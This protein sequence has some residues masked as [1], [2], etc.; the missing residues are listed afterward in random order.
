M[1]VNH[2]IRSTHESNLSDRVVAHLDV[3][4]GMDP[5]FFPRDEVVDEA[6]IAQHIQLKEQAAISVRARELNRPETHPDFDGQTCVECGEDIPPARLL[7]RR[8]RC[9]D[10]QTFLEEEAARRRRTSM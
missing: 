9:V 6:E 5:G 8:V 4:E 10:C 3:D 2:T 7:L 1:S